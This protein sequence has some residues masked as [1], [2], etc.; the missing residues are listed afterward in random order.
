MEIRTKS[1]KFDAD[2][3]LLDFVQKKV[4]KL[5]RFDETITSVDVTLALNEK[6]DNK[7]VKIQVHVKG[8]DIIVQRNAKSFED[9]INGCVDITK[10]KLTRNKEKRTEA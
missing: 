8:G 3:K 7:D 5:E 10:E 6:P 2:Q 4:S 1:L 9:A